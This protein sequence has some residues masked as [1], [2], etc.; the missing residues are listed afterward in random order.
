ML[1][2]SFTLCLVNFGPSNYL[3]VVSYVNDNQWPHADPFHVKSPAND[4]SQRDPGPYLIDG[5][6]GLAESTP[7]SGTWSPNSFSRARQQTDY[8]MQIVMY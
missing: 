1:V 5:S 2:N 6:Q 8:A 7:L 4:P 3:S